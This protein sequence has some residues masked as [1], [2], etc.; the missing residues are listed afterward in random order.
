MNFHVPKIVGIANITPDSFSGDGLLSKRSSVESVQ[1]YLHQM[2]DAGADIIDIGAE[3][4]A[5]GSSKITQEEELQRLYP[6]FKTSSEFKNLALD[7]TNAKTAKEAIAKGFCM[8]NDVSGGRKDSAMF[9]L[10]AE[11][12]VKYV[13][14][15]CKNDTGRADLEDNQD[16]VY[17]KII[18]FFDERIE[19]AYKSGIKKEQLILDPGMGAFISSKAED[20]LEVLKKIPDLKKRYNLPIYIGV[21]RKGFLATLTKNDSGPRS[22]IAPSL[23][24]GLYAAMQGADYLRVHDVLETRQVLDIFSSLKYL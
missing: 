17:K 20:S 22:R 18:Q 8:I 19:A 21:S 15:Y 23:S 12:G 1:E 7:T 9:S 5:P 11:T 4:T 14:M 3:S 2:F 6:I 10:I 16:S 24:A 13:M